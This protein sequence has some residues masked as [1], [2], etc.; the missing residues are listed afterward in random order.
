MTAM[1]T[2]GL[3]VAWHTAGDACGGVPAVGGAS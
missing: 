3:R 1:V 2:Q